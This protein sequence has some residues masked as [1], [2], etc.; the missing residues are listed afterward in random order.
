M[1]AVRLERRRSPDTRWLQHLSLLGALSLLFASA[2]ISRPQASSQIAEPLPG[3]F[4]APP[5]SPAQ[6]W[7]PVR[8]PVRTT[9]TPDPALAAQVAQA[10]TTTAASEALESSLDTNTLIPAGLTGPAVEWVQAHRK[11]ALFVAPDD[12]APR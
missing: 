8:V 10:A 4:L 9:I 12:G 7:L 11:T 5:S 3:S 6:E 2:V 1:Q